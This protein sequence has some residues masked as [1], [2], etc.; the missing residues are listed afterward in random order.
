MLVSN[1][2]AAINFIEKKTPRLNS[3]PTYTF[4]T[5]VQIKAPTTH[6]F[7]VLDMSK[8]LYY[9]EI[10]FDKW[11]HMFLSLDIS[12]VSKKIRTNIGAYS[13]CA[14]FVLRK[15]NLFCFL[16]KNKKCLVE[17]FLAPNFIFITNNTK[18]IIFKNFVST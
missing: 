12:E 16:C 4:F 6:I 13:L 15:G 11:Q 1:K 2:I 14:R 18:N 17:T 7:Y 10:H 5:I 9:M 8:S 3:T